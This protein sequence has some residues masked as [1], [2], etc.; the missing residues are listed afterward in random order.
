ME[1]L[2]LQ[3]I[4]LI[5]LV[6]TILAIIPYAFYLMALHKTLKEVKVEN[7]KMR[8]G[9]VWLLFI[10]V[11]STYWYFE[12]VNKMADS[13]KAEFE[14]RNIQSD[15]ERPGYAIGITMCIIGVCSIGLNIF[16]KIFEG[17]AVTMAILTF[18]I[19]TASFILFI[20]YWVKM[21]GYRKLIIEAK[22]SELR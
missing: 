9:Q 6:I 18:L 20:M 14:D 10:P 21:N 2:G 8:P 19:G 4:I 12:V 1:T 16:S 5:V 22:K 7:Q 3:E 17:L 13:L 11:F 15:E